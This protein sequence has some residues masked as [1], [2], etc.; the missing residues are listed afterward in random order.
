M[1]NNSCNL[2][3]FDCGADR[4][5][6]FGRCGAGN[7]PVVARAAAHYYEEPCISGENGSGAVFFSGCGLGCIFC[8]NA[9]ISQKIKGKEMDARTLAE[10]FDRVADTGVQ[11][12]NLGTPSHFAPQV[13]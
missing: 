3:P 7:N 4:I 2:C 1:E 5:T 8:Q 6:Q 12:I 11:N 10:V 13:A 9:D